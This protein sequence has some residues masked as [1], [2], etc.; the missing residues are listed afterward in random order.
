L[1]K[2][3]R[4]KG[5]AKFLDMPQPTLEKALRFDPDFA[6]CKPIKLGLRAVGYQFEDVVRVALIKICRRDGIPAERVEAEVEARL[7]DE[8]ARADMIAAARVRLEAKTRSASRAKGADHAF[9]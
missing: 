6:H 2:I 1:Q 5:F 9:P 7:I 8:L 3:I 4:I